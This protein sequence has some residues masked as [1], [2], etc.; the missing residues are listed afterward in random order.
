MGKY[1]Q[2][3]TLS[4]R[5]FLLIVYGSLSVQLRADNA[6][7]AQ[8]T[9]HQ[10]RI[11]LRE[12]QETFIPATKT[13][14]SQT[15]SK[16]TLK[17]EEFPQ[18]AISVKN[19]SKEHISDTLQ[20][21]DTKVQPRSI[22]TDVATP[23]PQF[24]APT[25]TRMWPTPV[26]Q[27]HKVISPP[28]PPESAP[29]RSVQPIQ[30]RPPASLES[31]VGLQT[32]P[33]AVQEHKQSPELPYPLSKPKE[34]M[35][36]PISS[37]NTQDSS[38]NTS[39]FFSQNALF[40]IFGVIAIILLIALIAIVRGRSRSVSESDASPL[41][42]WIRSKPPFEPYPAVEAIPE[43]H[44]KDTY[45][46]ASNDSVNFNDPNFDFLTPCSQITTIHAARS[47]PPSHN[48][49]LYSNMSSHVTASDWN[50]VYCT[51]ASW[52][53]KQ[54]RQFSPNFE[55]RGT[56][57]NDVTGSIN[58]FH[59]KDSDDLHSISSW[60]VNSEHYPEISPD[61]YSD[62]DDTEDFDSKKKSRVR[63]QESI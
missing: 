2:K 40:L 38:T 11:N 19:T 62:I 14:T 4:L 27:P 57:E 54:P 18:K 16:S 8:E 41:T 43:P 28:M 61:R 6:S 37:S 39:N 17:N 33:A 42:P 26:L 21:S 30:M 3:P 34:S 12:S 20:K 23:T 56:G 35:E 52:I 49:Q 36:T 32:T 47:Y 60:A 15:D 53:A 29:N 51:T 44:Y 10:P 31:Q 55:P 58:D 13:S 48:S 24:K 59:S 45:M 50:K 22:F 46:V 1:R 25:S 9:D 5:L 63:F 7:N